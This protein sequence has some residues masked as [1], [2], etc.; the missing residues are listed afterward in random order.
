MGI[1]AQDQR[2]FREHVAM[3]VSWYTRNFPIPFH[4]KRGQQDLLTNSVMDVHNATHIDDLAKLANEIDQTIPHEKPFEARLRERFERRQRE[5]QA[6]NERDRLSDTIILEELRPN[7]ANF[8]GTARVYSSPHRYSFGNACEK[9]V[10]EL[11]TGGYGHRRI[12]TII[13]SKDFL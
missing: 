5:E 13:P 3:R 1:E 10:K 2:R 12:T 4:I 7:V 11:N 6:K 8:L 9:I